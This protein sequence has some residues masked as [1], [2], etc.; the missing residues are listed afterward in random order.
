M[1]NSK[2]LELIKAFDSRE[3]KQLI[4]FVHCY[5][6]SD[7]YSIVLL[8]YILKVAPN[9]ESKRLSKEKVFKT[10]FPQK[11]DYNDLVMRRCMSRLF[12]LCEE[13]IIYLNI[14]SNKHIREIELLNFYEDRQLDSHFK[15]TLQS[16]R[17]KSKKEELV[18]DL[19][20]FYEFQI[21]KELLA[22]HF[23]QNDRVNKPKLEETSY[24][25]DSFFLMNKLKVCC[26]SITYQ[27]LSNTE[28]ELP[29]MKEALTYLKR[30]W[31]DCSPIVQAYYFALLS[32]IDEGEENHFRS[33]KEI[34]FSF[35]NEF[36]T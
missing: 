29:M 12:Q 33:L 15:N 7:S 28:Y 4:A 35:I 2:L 3:R 22:D 18:D 19:H 1:H 8:E 16:W 9:F 23:A 26:S 21:D 27:T 36:F 10:V 17:K 5:N 25:L 6:R 34:L 11:P 13:Y 31:K 20:F 14:Q 32:L 30:K 24:N